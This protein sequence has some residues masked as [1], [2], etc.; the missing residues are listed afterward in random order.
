MVDKDTINLKQMV[1]DH[2]E[3]L[4]KLET[5]V[6]HLD[7][8]LDEQTATLKEVRD[9]VIGVGKAIKI[10]VAIIGLVGTVIGLFG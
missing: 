3:R 4:V 1:Y 9:E 7:E 6:T 5:I 2:G 10:G 8:R